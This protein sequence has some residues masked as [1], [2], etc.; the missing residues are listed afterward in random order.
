M[1]VFLRTQTFEYLASTVFV[2]AEE[3]MTDMFH[4][5][6]YLVS[7]TGLQLTLYER[8][9]REPLQYPPVGD[10]LLGLRTILEVPYA[11]DGSV[12]IVASQRSFDG[13]AVFLERTPNEGIV[14]PLGGMI[15]E[16][17]G[18]M[19]LRFRRLGDE[20]QSARV[21]VY[22]VNQTNIGIIDVDW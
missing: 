16:L 19:R 5:Y 7:T 13:S 8:H 20:Q 2:V 10:R 15:E 3:R 11:V 1:P 22:A 18:Q 14:G 4:V 21:F 9:V 6:A 12:T 17:L